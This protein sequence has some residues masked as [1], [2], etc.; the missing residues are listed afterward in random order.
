MVATAVVM[1][2]N[3]TLGGVAV[4]I[5]QLRII[6]EEIVSIGKIRKLL[7]RMVDRMIGFSD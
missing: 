3:V 2:W 1:K 7:V 5:L 6:V 4:D